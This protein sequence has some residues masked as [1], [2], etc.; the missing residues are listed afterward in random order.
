MLVSMV[1]VENRKQ[2]QSNRDR[3]NTANSETGCCFLVDGYRE[4]DVRIKLND[5]LEKS[6]EK[7]EE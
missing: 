2:C 5:V 4:S 7:K 3:G 6:K 1:K